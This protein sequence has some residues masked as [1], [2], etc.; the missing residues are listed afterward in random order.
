MLPL[1]VLAFRSWVVI[2]IGSAQP[3]QHS[4]KR[5]VSIMMLE[6][7]TFRTQPPS[8]IWMDRPRLV[9]VMMQLSTRIF[10]KSATPSVPILIAALVEVSVQLE[11]MTFLVGPYSLLPAVVLRQMQ[12]SAHWTWQ[13]MIRTLVE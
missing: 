5:R 6:K 4:A 13:P 1:W 11:M 7:L 2:T 3:H 9:P 8:R 12:S 10:S